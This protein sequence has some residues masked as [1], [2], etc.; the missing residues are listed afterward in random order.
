LQFSEIGILFTKKKTLYNIQTNRGQ[1]FSYYNSLL[2]SLKNSN[3]P[4]KEIEERNDKLNFN[5]ESN[6]IKIIT[7]HSVKGYE[8]KVVFLINL[9]N[10]WEYDDLTRSLIYVGITRAQDLL[11]IP[12]LRNGR[13]FRYI[14]EMENAIENIHSESIE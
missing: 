5:F 3:I 7:I 11:Y 8:F 12:Y 10:E 2:Q 13:H 4:F 14:R 1:P 9:E 6:E